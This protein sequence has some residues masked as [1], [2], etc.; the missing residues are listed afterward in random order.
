MKKVYLAIF[1]AA[2]FAIAG[3]DKKD[4]PKSNA[5]DEAFAI[6]AARSNRAE[7]EL[8]V[9]AREHG[10][11]HFIREFGATMET[12]HRVALSDLQALADQKNLVLPGSLSAS[13]QQLKQRL[14]ML[15][16]VEFDTAY[17][18]SQIKAHEKAIDEFNTEANEGVDEEFRTWASTMLPHMYEHL[19]K[20]EAVRDSVMAKIGTPQ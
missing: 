10:D 17:I 2:T 6:N 9:L 15:Y 18:N 11:S 4:D 5:P 1:I 3:C 20:A 19:D 13:D 16:G 12:E 8:G 14:M 7:M